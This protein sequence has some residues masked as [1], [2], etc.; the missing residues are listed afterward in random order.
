MPEKMRFGVTDHQIIWQNQLRIGK[1]K[2]L[3]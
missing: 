2:R 3:A 1:L